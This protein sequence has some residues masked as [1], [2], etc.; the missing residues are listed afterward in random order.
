MNK[1][2]VQSAGW[3]L[4]VPATLFLVG[5]GVSRQAGLDRSPA[6]SGTAE[7]ST[8]T[9][10]GDAGDAAATTQT[11]EKAQAATAPN[12]NVNGWSINSGGEAEMASSSYRVGMS[13]GQPVAGEAASTS[14]RVGVGFWYGV[15]ADAAACP[16]DVAGDVNTSGSITSADII[17]LVNF[18]FKGGDAPLPCEANGDVNC[19]GSITSAD[20]IHLVNY[21]FKGGDSS[22]DICAEIPGQ[23]SCP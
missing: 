2:R 3:A 12:F 4:V 6:G 7:V 17:Y 20:I 8:V 14:Y 23:W 9:V 5:A 15:E 13:A 11:T 16:I 21:V 10:A 1:R 22:C 19:S 18:V